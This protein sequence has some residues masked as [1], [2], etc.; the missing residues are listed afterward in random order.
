[1]HIMS[2]SNIDIHAKGVA[3]V[4][5]GR[6]A[7]IEELRSGDPY[8]VKPSRQDVALALAD[9]S[10]VSSWQGDDVDGYD[11]PSAIVSSE[12]G[13]RVKKFGRTTGLSFGTVEAFI[14]T[15][16]PLPYRTKSF[17]ATVYFEEVWTVRADDGE[18]FALPGDSGSL[19]VTEDA[20]AAVGL[21]FAASP[22]GDYGFI[23]PMDHVRTLLGGMHLVAKHNV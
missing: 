14:N 23:L 10:R 21:V 17:T 18:A 3:P 9:D 12:S 1:M 6:H 16:T 7:E 2:P 8:L 22:K 4:S 11:T 20:K 19:V 15:P 5:V 13:M